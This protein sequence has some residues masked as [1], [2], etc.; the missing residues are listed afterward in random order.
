MWV[1]FSSLPF[2]LGA[3]ILQ[4]YAEMHHHRIEPKPYVAAN[5][6]HD[7]YSVY[8]RIHRPWRIPGAEIDSSG[9]RDFY[10]SWF[11]FCPL[12]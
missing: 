1:F 9:K 5:E 12:S 4:S 11:A 7:Q 3:E 2:S 10:P 8:V 6:I